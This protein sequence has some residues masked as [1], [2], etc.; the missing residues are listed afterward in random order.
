MAMFIGSN[1]RET[2]LG[3]LEEIERL[4]KREDSNE[5][6]ASTVKGRERAVYARGTLQEL[7][8]TISLAAQN[9][10]TPDLSKLRARMDP[11]VQLQLL[12]DRCAQLATQLEALAIVPGLTFDVVVIEDDSDP[13][14][15]PTFR[16]RIGGRQCSPKYVDRIGAL[17]AAVATMEEI[18]APPINE[19]Q[20]ARRI[21]AGIATTITPDGP[22]PVGPS[23][24]AKGNRAQ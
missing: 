12:T 9:G 22:L 15:P 17:T 5:R 14:I 1:D 8:N 16:Y 24:I 20:R 6:R 13:A 3:V 10:P 11:E 18:L 4:M 19:E 23:L 7:H 2:L 21:L